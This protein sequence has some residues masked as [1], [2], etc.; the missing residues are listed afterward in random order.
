LIRQSGEN[1]ERGRIYNHEGHEEH[2][3]RKR[4]NLITKN[5]KDTKKKAR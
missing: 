4:K 3:G 5:T 1:E 2:K